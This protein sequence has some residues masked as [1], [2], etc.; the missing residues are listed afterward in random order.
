MKDYTNFV[1]LEVRFRLE[2]GTFGCF[3]SQYQFMTHHTTDIREFIKIMVEY[4]FYGKCNIVGT[5]TEENNGKLEYKIYHRDTIY[6]YLTNQQEKFTNKV[7]DALY[8]RIRYFL[9][10]EMQIG[11]LYANLTPSEFIEQLWQLFYYVFRVDFYMLRNEEY[12]SSWEEM[13]AKLFSA[14]VQTQSIQT[15]QRMTEQF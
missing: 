7:S 14:A 5:K 3:H 8:Y 4:L 11:K 10:P 15:L 13:I 12:I 6:K 2:K 9:N 1:L